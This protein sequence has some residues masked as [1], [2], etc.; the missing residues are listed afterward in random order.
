MV[1]TSRCG[2]QPTITE[3][4]E[5]RF[6]AAAIPFAFSSCLSCL[7]RCLFMNVKADVGLGNT[8]G[9]LLW[10]CS[11]REGQSARESLSLEG[12]CPCLLI[13]NLVIDNNRTSPSRTLGGATIVFY[14]LIQIIA[15]SLMSLQ[16]NVAKCPQE[17]R[18]CV[19]VREKSTPPRATPNLR[20]E[21]HGS[22]APPSTIP[23][24]RA[25]HST[26]EGSSYV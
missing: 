11:G 25:G 23:N 15:T 1:S 21:P 3:R 14:Q 24:A 4:T 17:V 8:P 9:F 2:F 16:I 5:V 13:Y 6:L 20:T 26:V 12:H 18:V 19:V 7:L 10:S 22:E